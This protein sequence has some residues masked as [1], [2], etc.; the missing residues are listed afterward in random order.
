[1]FVGTFMMQ[2]KELLSGKIS[3]DVE[4]TSLAVCQA[5]NVM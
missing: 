1:M 5:P 2:M 3:V 4:V